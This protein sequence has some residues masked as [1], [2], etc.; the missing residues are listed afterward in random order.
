MQAVCEAS[1]APVCHWLDLRPVW[2][3]GD[4]QDGLH[5]TESGGEHVGD[6]IWSELVKDCLAQ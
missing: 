6:L 5:P 4:T 2:V 1:T 3:D